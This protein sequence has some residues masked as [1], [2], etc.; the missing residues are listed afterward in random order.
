[1]SLQQ[2]L[3][4]V[5][6]SEI[7][8]PASRSEAVLTFLNMS[9][10]DGVGSL[11][12]SGLVAFVY[13]NFAGGGL[14]QYV[15]EVNCRGVTGGEARSLIARHGYACGANQNEPLGELH[16]VHIEG[17]SVIEIMCRDVKLMA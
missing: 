4:D 8:F 15:G 9:D 2:L 7:E 5:N 17:D 14:P 1:M 11:V 12:C 10:G 3:V 16:H 6:L 13:H